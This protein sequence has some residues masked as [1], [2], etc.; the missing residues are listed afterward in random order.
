MSRRLDKV[1]KML[2]GWIKAEKRKN[3]EIKLLISHMFVRNVAQE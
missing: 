3:Q 2:G 1:G